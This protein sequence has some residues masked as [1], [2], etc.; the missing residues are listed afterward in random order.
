MLPALRNKNRGLPTR[1][2]EAPRASAQN[3]L[4]RWCCAGTTRGKALRA[5]MF[6]MCSGL[7]FWGQLWRLRLLLSLLVTAPLCRRYD[8]GRVR[9]I[10]MK[11]D[12]D[13]IRSSE[14]RSAT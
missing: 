14:A 5:T 11:D 1:P 3:W 13:A 9:V 2:A 7:V 4:R 12:I 6:G 8:F 10:A